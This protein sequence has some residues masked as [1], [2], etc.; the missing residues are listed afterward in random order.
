MLS[1]VCELLH[2][3][4]CVLGYPRAGKQL[5]QMP[6]KSIQLERDTGV[7][8]HLWNQLASNGGGRRREKNT[9]KRR[10]RGRQNTLYFNSVR[11]EMQLRRVCL[12]TKMSNA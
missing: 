7:V 10:E 9:R 5:S 2:L 11:L 12:L 8:I 3:S 1:A 6:N 4:H